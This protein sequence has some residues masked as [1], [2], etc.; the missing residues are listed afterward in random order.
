MKFSEL[1]RVDLFSPYTLVIII[2][3]Y[4]SLAAI[5][6]QEHLKNLQWISITTFIYVLIGTLF[7]IMGVFVPKIIHD[8]S[9]KLKSI[10]RDLK[11][12]EDNSEQ[13]YNKCRVLLDERVLLTAVLIAL[14]LQGLNLYLLGGIPI[15]SG[16]LKFKATTDLWRI[17]YPLFLPAIQFSW[18]NILVNGIMYFSS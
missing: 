4:V 2:A 7:F 14:F 6:Y 3:I 8:H 15:L 16:Y 1:K 11:V 10:F 5:A 9:V 12:T 17:A 13:W 18:L